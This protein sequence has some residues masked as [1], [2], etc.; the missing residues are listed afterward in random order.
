M[1]SFK[2]LDALETKQLNEIMSD[3]KEQYTKDEVINLLKE[4][5]LQYRKAIYNGEYIFDIESL[6]KKDVKI[7]DTEFSVQKLVTNDNKYL[8]FVQIT[9]ILD[10]SF[11]EKDIQDMAEE[12]NKAIKKADNIA[13]VI[14][15]PSNMEISLVTAKLETLSYAKELNFSDED[16]ILL[17]KFES[18]IN[19]KP[20][21]FTKLYDS[22]NMTFK[23]V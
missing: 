4:V 18:V 11:G 7:K 14:I 2:Y 15:L 16:Y 20:I 13:G 8:L 3:S 6:D 22:V 12:I 17:D 10:E 19:K 23:Q 21:T 5:R 1:N 9:N